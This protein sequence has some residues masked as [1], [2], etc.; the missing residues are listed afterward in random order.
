MPAPVAWLVALG[1]MIAAITL[2]I[3]VAPVDGHSWQLVSVGTGVVL[4]AWVGTSVVFGI[5]VTQV[6]DYDSIFGNLAT[7]IIVFEYFYL[8]ACA[9]LTG[10]LLDAI[11][12]ERA[13]G[14]EG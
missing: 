14:L 12:R 10:A 1:F 2:L 5:Y 4:V 13:A 8:A 6:A 9:F 11:M 7:V 3:R